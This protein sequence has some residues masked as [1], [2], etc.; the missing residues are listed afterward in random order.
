VLQSA[1]KTLVDDDASLVME[2]VVA[3]L[4]KQP[5]FEVRK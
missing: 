3:V 1:T 2:E 5:N 4:E